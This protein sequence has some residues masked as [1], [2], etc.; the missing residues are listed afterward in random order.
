M[1]SATLIEGKREREKEKER[2]NGR[3]TKVLNVPANFGNGALFTQT[4][5]CLL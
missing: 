3:G 5:M 4:V 1:V 2:Q